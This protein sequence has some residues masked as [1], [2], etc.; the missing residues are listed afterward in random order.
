VVKEE[1]ATDALLGEVLGNLQPVAQEKGILLALGENTSCRIESDPGQL[2]RVL[3]NLLDNALK[4]TPAGGRVEVSAGYGGGSWSVTVADTGVGISPEHL[5]HVFERFYRADPART[6]EG[7]GA[8]LGLAI[9]HSIV[10]SLG[11]AITLESSAGRGTKV[12]V[13]FPVTVR[14]D[15][16]SDKPGG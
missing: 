1:V 4:Y 15:D 9:C 10:K 16:T 3:Y 12:R 7:S 14:A 5:A 2:R 6:G 11:G 13:T 8:G